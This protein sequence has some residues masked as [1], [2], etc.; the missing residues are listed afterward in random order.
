[1]RNEISDMD[2]CLLACSSELSLFFF[3][4]SKV[5]QRRKTDGVLWFIAWRQ[6][7]RQ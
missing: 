5:D 6:M 1:M 4:V 7:E 2:E 3:Y